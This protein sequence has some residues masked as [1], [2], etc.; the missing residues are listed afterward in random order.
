MYGV[1][2]SQTISSAPRQPHSIQGFMIVLG[3]QNSFQPRSHTYTLGVLDVFFVSFSL[4]LTSLAFLINSTT[5]VASR[6]WRA[7]SGRKLDILIS[8]TSVHTTTRVVMLWR[9]IVY[10]LWWH[11]DI[12]MFKSLWAKKEQH[13]TIISTYMY[14]PLIWLLFY[15]EV[16]SR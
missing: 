6:I 10:R 8:R 5:T 16:H 9:I 14:K 12:Y 1:H 2:I 11:P 13:A 3:T 4:S 15:R 7:R